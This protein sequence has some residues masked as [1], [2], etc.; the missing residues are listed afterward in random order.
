MYAH[1]GDLAHGGPRRRKLWHALLLDAWIRAHFENPFR[2]DG[3]SWENIFSRSRNLEY[4]AW[5][6]RDGDK[7][8]DQWLTTNEAILYCR[9]SKSFFYT[10]SNGIP[11]QGTGK[12]RRFHVPAL[13]EWLVKLSEYEKPLTVQRRAEAKPEVVFR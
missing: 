10:L 2:N 1:I 3:D 13:D 8:V 7:I 11:H 12:H 6:W 5:R 4:G 9:L